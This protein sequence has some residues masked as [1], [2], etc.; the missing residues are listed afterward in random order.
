VVAV[1]RPATPMVLRSL[2]TVSVLTNLAATAVTFFV[3]DVLT[4]PAVMNGSARGT[5]IVMLVAGLPVLLASFALEDRGLRWAAVMRL[6]ALAYLAYNDFLLLFATPFNSLFLAYVVALSSTAFALGISLA[7]SESGLVHRTL[8]RTPSRVVGGYIWVI[9]VLNALIWLRTI[10]PATFAVNPG[11][12]LDGTGIAT[13]P[14]F[15]QDLV[16]WLPS[17]TLIGWL[18]WSHRSWGVLLAGAYLV[19]GL[20]E[21]I[22]VAV[23]QWMGSSADPSSTVASMG[24]VWIFGVLAVIGV[25]ALA[26]YARSVA[27]ARD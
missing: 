25:V 9:V 1:A 12:F 18:A 15:V 3:P 13:N 5:A 7:T 21:S 8:G 2:L 20:L 10:V 22:G 6:G 27:A 24:A 26:F 11:S 23:D 14:V 4:G 19:Y 17:A 16:F